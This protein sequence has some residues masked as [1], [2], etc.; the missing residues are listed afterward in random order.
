MEAHSDWSRE[1]QQLFEAEKEV[2]IDVK[3][4][5]LDLENRNNGIDEDFNEKKVGLYFHFT[6]D[7]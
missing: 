2:K 5:I 4:V 1:E 7:I 6:D 3:A